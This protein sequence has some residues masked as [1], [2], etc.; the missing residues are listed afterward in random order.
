MR[1]PNFSDATN[2][3]LSRF[4][5]AEEDV[6]RRFDPRWSWEYA[7][8]FHSIHV[9]QPGVYG[10]LE[11]DGDQGAGLYLFRPDD[12]ILSNA[13]YVDTTQPGWTLRLQRAL[14][15]FNTRARKNPPAVGLALHRLCQ[16]RQEDVERAL[17]TRLDLTW[18]IGPYE[19]FKTPRGFGVTFHGHQNAEWGMC[20]IRLSRKLLQSPTSR[21]DGIIRH[22]LGHV[23]DLSFRPA[24][25]NRWA[26]KRGVQLPPQQQG[27][28]RADAIAHAV[29][30]EPLLY[31]EATVQN[32]TTGTWPRP[33]HLGL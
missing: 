3:I 2:Y 31:D 26:A 25:V 12:W 30:G 6:Q 5:L 1:K 7:D 20:H 8:Q 17:G 33:H 32:T 18:D 4:P 13:V 15:Q 11:E 24:D 29:W 10:K 9:F 23:V 27:E 14:K 22:E 28:L 19:H 21:Q 16:Q